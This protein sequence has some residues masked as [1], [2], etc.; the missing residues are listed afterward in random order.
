MEE[1]VTEPDLLGGGEAGRGAGAE[2][3]RVT[4]TEVNGD[5][6]GT[7]CLREVMECPMEPVVLQYP[8]EH[9]QYG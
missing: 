3:G 2:A 4:R 8:T 7:P 1:E 9:N 5:L 6:P